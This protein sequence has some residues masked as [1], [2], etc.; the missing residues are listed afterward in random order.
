MRAVGAS[1]KEIKKR[2][3]YVLNLV[4]LEQ[5]AKA[6]RPNSPAANS[7]GLLLPGHW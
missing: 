3:P 1:P 7:S 2:I 6:T 4:G 5:R